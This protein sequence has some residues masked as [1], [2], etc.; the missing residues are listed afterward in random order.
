MFRTLGPVCCASLSSLWTVSWLSFR[1]EPLDP[2]HFGFSRD[3]AGLMG[4]IRTSLT[5]SMIGSLLSRKVTGFF[6]GVS[7]S[8]SP[9]LI[10]PEFPMLGLEP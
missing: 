5:I 3:I 7:I 2:L 4:R 10:S 9:I 6:V 8:R 1:L